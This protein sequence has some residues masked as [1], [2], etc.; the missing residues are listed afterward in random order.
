MYD[1]YSLYTIITCTWLK[2]LTFTHKLVY[3]SPSMKLVE[4][5]AFTV[6]S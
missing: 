5:K 2:L 3:T 6:I 1:N 4:N